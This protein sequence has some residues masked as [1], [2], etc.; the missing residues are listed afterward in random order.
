MS[1]WSQSKCLLATARTDAEA[2]ILWPPDSKTRLLG[3]DLIL[4]KTEC[5]RRSGQQRMRWLDGI[6]DSMDVTFS[7]LQETMSNRGAWHAAI[8]GVAESDTTELLKNNNCL[9]GNNLFSRPKKN[10]HLFCSLN[11]SFKSECGYMP[12]VLCLDV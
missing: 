10:K 12:P 1:I 8:P 11:L 3:K 2:P 7:K 4:G 6:T 9:C 5:R